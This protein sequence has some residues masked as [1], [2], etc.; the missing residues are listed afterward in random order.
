MEQP[1]RPDSF[2]AKAIIIPALKVGGLAAT[3]TTLLHTQ[4]ANATPTDRLHASGIAGTLTGGTIAALTRGPRN[5]LPGAIMFTLF[6]YAGQ[7]GYSIL[8]SR[9]TDKVVAEAEA[10][11]QG[12]AKPPFWQRVA[13]MKWSPLKTLSDEEYGDMLREKLLRVEAEIALVDEEVGRLRAEDERVETRS[14]DEASGKS[15]ERK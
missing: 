15:E 14:K 12:T 11:S 1:E 9:H 10:E 2:E 5:I 8:D 7:T 6:G 13:E 4:Y 3:R